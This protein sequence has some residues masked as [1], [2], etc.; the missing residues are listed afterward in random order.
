MTVGPATLSPDEVERETERDLR[1][2]IRRVRDAGAVPVLL[3][4]P[5]RLMNGEPVNRATERVAAHERVLFFDGEHVTQE[6][7]RRGVPGLFFSDMH[8]T[9]RYYVVFARDLARRLA[10][11][12]LL[13]A[14]AD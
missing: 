5:T 12:G 2:M 11:S 3:S 7:V 9:G 13:P 1:A 6:L 14:P 10:E 4:Y 8:P